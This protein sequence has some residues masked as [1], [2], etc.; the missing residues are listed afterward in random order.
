MLQIFLVQF[1]MSKMSENTQP[2]VESD[3]H[4]VPQSAQIVGTVV[5]S[6][7]TRPVMVIAS[8]EVHK[9]RQKPPFFVR[10]LV[11]LPKTWIGATD[12]YVQ[13]VLA[14]LGSQVWTSHFHDPQNS[15]CFDSTESM[16]MDGVLEKTHEVRSQLRRLGTVILTVERLLPIIG[17]LRGLPPQFPDRRLRVR[18]AQELCHILSTGSTVFD[19]SNDL[20]GFRRHDEGLATPSKHHFFGGYRSEM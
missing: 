18:N 3:E 11:F 20:P 9:D 7:A 16:P 17:I 4:D 12:V 10:A 19:S 15:V 6:P 1:R 5:V 14:L 8:V 2:V 13:A